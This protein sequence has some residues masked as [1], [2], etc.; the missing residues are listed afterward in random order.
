MILKKSSYLEKKKRQTQQ[1]IQFVIT[2]SLQEADK[3]IQ[4]HS[5]ERLGKDKIYLLFTRNKERQ[6]PATS[7]THP[8]TFSKI[9]AEN[10]VNEANFKASQI[11]E[12]IKMK[13][14]HNE[15]KMDNSKREVTLGLNR[16]FIKKLENCLLLETVKCEIVDTVSMIV[17]GLGYGDVPISGIGSKRFLTNFEGVASTE[18]IDIEFKK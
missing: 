3:M 17:E 13:Y 18:D 8:L 16:S 1:K 10:M 12:T 14:L 5:G 11:K 7:G 4:S 15:E 6:N 9:K 2:R